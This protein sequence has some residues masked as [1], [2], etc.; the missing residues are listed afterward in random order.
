MRAGLR[1]PEKSLPVLCWCKLQQVHWLT[2]KCIY[3]VKQYHPILTSVFVLA[4]IC[5]TMPK[6]HKT[7]HQKK[8]VPSWQLVFRKSL[9]LHSWELPHTTCSLPVNIIS[10][11]FATGPLPFPLQLCLSLVH[12]QSLSDSET[13]KQCLPWVLF[14]PWHWAA[15]VVVRSSLIC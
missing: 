14:L 15:A 5:I 11:L 6:A 7:L 3:I 8:V 12:K 13:S 9:S 2:S 4:D 10:S 1:A